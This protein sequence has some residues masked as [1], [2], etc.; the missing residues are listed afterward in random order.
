VFLTEWHFSLYC[1]MPRDGMFDWR[2]NSSSRSV[3]AR[4]LAV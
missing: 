4:N 1:I 2:H 3:A